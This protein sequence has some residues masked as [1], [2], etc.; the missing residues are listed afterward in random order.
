LTTFGQRLK[1]LR[2]DHK[3]TQAEL[4][5]RLQAKRCTL[6]KWETGEASPRI[7]N[8]RKIA[9]FFNVSLDDLYKDD[10]RS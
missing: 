8:I 3:L 10:K 2:K 1:Q 5:D 4:A 7:N 6:A 9:E